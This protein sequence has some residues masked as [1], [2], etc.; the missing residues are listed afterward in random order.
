MPFLVEEKSTV[1]AKGQTT[2]P[3]IVREALGVGPGDQ[4]AYRLDSE[5]R[6]VLGR[7]EGVSDEAA[8]DAFLAFLSND[9]KSRPQAVKRLSGKKAERRRR[10]VAGVEADPD[11]DFSGA[12]NI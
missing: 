4:I 10:L 8:V 2:V 12:T 3:K 5:G 11:A 7:Y 1:T 9:I 6:V